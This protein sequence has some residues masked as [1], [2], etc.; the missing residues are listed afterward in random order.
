ML[1]LGSQNADVNP[2]I[3]FS[4]VKDALITSNQVR[5]VQEI[6]SSYANKISRFVNNAF[7]LHVHF[8]AYDKAGTRRKFIVN[9]RIDY[10]G[11]NRME[12]SA[13]SWKAKRALHKALIGLMNQA[14]GIHR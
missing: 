4:G 11:K 10:P 6:A 12:S 5:R 9:T 3:V 13:H 8:K 14:E 7:T 1:N 2:K